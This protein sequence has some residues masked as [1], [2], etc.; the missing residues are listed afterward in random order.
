MAFSRR[1]IVFTLLGALLVL[2]ASRAFASK[3]AD[4]FPMYPC[5]K[6][7]VA[8]WKKVYSVYSTSQAILHDRRDLDV[9]YEVI[10]LKDP[11]SAGAGRYNSEKIKQAKAKT[12]RL[13]RGLASG[14][15]PVTDEEKR[16]HALFVAKAPRSLLKDAHE[17]VR[18]QL[19]Q[20]DRFRSGVIRSGAYLGEIKQVFRQSGLPEDLAYLPHVESSFNYEAYSKAGAAGIWQFTHG[21]GKRFMTIDYTVDE[22]RDPIQAT[23][24]AAQF[25]KEN[26]AALGDWPMALTAY[27][28]GTGGMLRAKRAKGDYERIFKEYQGPAF[29]FASRNF[30]SEFLA[31]REIAKDYRRY[32]GDLTLDKPV[33]RHAV[34]LPGYVS[35][36][37]LAR[38][39]GVDEKT[40]RQYNPSLREPVF[41]GQK[42]VPKGFV[43]HLP[44]EA[45]TGTA[46][47]AE[48]PAEMLKPQQKASKFYRVRKGDT[49]GEIAKR[50]G[51]SLKDLIAANGL[52]SRATVYA[53]QNLRIPGQGEKIV[54]AAPPAETRPAPAAA[55]VVARA[56]EASPKKP[57]APAPPAKAPAPAKK[58]EPAPAPTPAPAPAPMPAPPP[59]P[60]P[61][62]EVE[63]AGQELPDNGLKPLEEPLDVNPAVVVGN[64]SVEKVFIRKGVSFGVIQVE[65][66]ETLG[67]YADWLQIPTQQIRNL[68]GFSSK[69][70]IRVGQK[71]E[72][73]F[74]RVT[75][76][77]FE[78]KRY[79]Y[80]KEIE[81]DFFAAYAVERIMTYRIEPGDNIW[82]L[83]QKKFALP[84]WLLKKYN[85]EMD[86]GR[87]TASRPLVIPVV[88][89]IGEA[90]GPT[91]EEENGDVVEGENGES[92]AEAEAQDGA[93]MTG[94]PS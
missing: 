50:H 60:E 42:Y 84:F 24:A 4:P 68:N 64:L 76:E 34:K 40:L 88:A 22:R 2:G 53:G 74:G 41:K 58:P 80:H 85:P 9:I 78:E 38:R 10:E 18:M 46:L 39:Y 37:D 70:S 65:P 31:A 1:T 66:E 54:A 11:K 33:R 67:H 92:G 36:H 77:Q 19:G 47:A 32:F 13:L 79:E 62:A 94:P 91:V 52:N 86:F 55:T 27:N 17:N 14:R 16:V 51:V 6:S 29:G 25:L 57:A 71:I 87:L 45:A 35:I 7:N 61:V 48:I 82:K 63:P 23:H 20:K 30:Y 59:E 83:C 15:A 93:V 49:A 5:L 73:P 81:E 21:T 75:R 3:G 26:Y 44:G 8:F 28:H 12:E 56:P 90:A 72:I 89:R 43:L 69:R